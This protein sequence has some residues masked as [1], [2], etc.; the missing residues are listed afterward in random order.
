MRLR[1]MFLLALVPLVFA[2]KCQCQKG[3][4]E[5]GERGGAGLVPYEINGRIKVTNDC[6]GKLASIPD[7]VTVFT[8]LE[9]KD[10]SVAVPGRA[11]ADLAP[12]PNDPDNPIKIGWYSLQVGW[13][14]AA[15]SGADHWTPPLLY[16]G[17]LAPDPTPGITPT[18]PPESRRVC[19][20]IE[21]ED[22]NSTCKNVADESA[23]PAAAVPNATGHDIEVV[24]VCV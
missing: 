7:T 18:P 10:G 5:G 12:D 13:P 1:S 21:C 9:N 4:G 6:D 19:A 23:V 11:Q 3:G 22:D 20:T 24:C 15:T 16:K 17:E 14:E 2:G 8:Y